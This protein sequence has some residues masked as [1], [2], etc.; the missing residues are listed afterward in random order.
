MSDFQ[1][2]LFILGNVWKN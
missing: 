1:R 2:F